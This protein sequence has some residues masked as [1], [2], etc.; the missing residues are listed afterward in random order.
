MNDD[1]FL[2]FQKNLADYLRGRK[3]DFS[4]AAVEWMADEIVRLRAELT[5]LEKEKN[6][7]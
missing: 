7:S 5:K 3:M 1:P 6:H 4:A 2:E